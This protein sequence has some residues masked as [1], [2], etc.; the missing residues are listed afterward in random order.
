VDNRDSVQPA[1]TTF[2]L[3]AN[4]VLAPSGFQTTT[5]YI[6]TNPAADDSS[7]RGFA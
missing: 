3:S 5:P 2:L 1:F 4:L 6:G 7:C